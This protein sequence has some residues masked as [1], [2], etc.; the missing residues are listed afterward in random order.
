MTN[1]ER[2]R[3]WMRSVGQQVPE[4][5]GMGSQDRDLRIALLDE[6]VNEAIEA[7]DNVEFDGVAPAAK[8]L[9]DVLVIAYGGLVAMGLDPDSVFAI[10]QD[11]NDAK[12]QHAVER[13]DGKCIVPPEV[14]QELKAETRRRLEALVGD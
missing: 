14:K 2:V 4:S 1:A 3:A 12:V 5:P 11:E 7:L 10:V 6:E 9:A 13:E 8:E